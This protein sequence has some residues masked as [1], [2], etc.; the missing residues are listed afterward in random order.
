MPPHRH[1]KSR[2]TRFGLLK[3]DRRSLQ[4]VLSPIQK[5]ASNPRRTKTVTASDNKSQYEEGP[6]AREPA[7]HH[8]A[9]DYA[10]TLTASL[11]VIC[12][13]VFTG[14]VSARLLQPTGRGQLAS[15][16]LWPIFL[17]TIALFGMPESVTYFAARHREHS[18]QYLS[19][20]LLIALGFSIPLIGIAYFALPHV[21][22]SKGSMVIAGARLYLLFIPCYAFLF[23]PIQAVR[24]V[25][26]VRLWNILRLL[27]TVA[28]FL[29]LLVLLLLSKIDHLTFTATALADYYLA[30]LGFL[31]IVT[32]SIAMVSLMGSARPESS[33]M[34][35]LLRYGLPVAG[36]I[37]PI[38]LVLQ[39]DQLVMTIVVSPH[40]LGLYVVAVSWGAAVSPILN[41][42]G[43]LM[44]PRI[45]S[46]SDTPQQHALVIRTAR[47]AILLAIAVTLPILI[48][49]PIAIHVIFGSSYGGS[50][51]SAYVLVLASSFLGVSYIVSE[52]ILGLGLTRGPLKAGIVGCLTTGVSLAILLPSLGI[53]GAALSSL[54]GYSSMAGVLLVEARN[55]TG[56]RFR[57]LCIPKVT[58]IR[59]YFNVCRDLLR[60][61]ANR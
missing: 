30:S 36:A 35:P 16:Q 33:M 46:R 41:S 59:M 31:S 54:I 56:S 47:L 38:M 8:I 26:K 48:L 53:L 22:N 32:I 29:I 1:P 50:V 37:L 40:A 10:T 28:W 18:R 15:I 14:S 3:R 7:G 45:A 4:A 12:L 57:N 2:S 11:L 58:D 17:A 44:L 24:G 39:L 6:P 49:T 21:L 19:N 60:A 55:A 42:L 43:S 27:P 5:F 52:S 9:H 51:S 61:R 34:R 23:L 13:G 25:G 20:A